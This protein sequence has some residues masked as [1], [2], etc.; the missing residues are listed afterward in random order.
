MS[1]KYRET[2]SKVQDAVASYKRNPK[3]KIAPLA[4][5]FDVPVQRLHARI[6]G[7]K[8]RSELPRKNQRLGCSQMSVIYAWIDHLNTAGTPPTRGC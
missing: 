6:K 8:S 1:S 3:Q 7:R 2:E 5:E 4:R